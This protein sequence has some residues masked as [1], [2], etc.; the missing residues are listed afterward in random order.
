V[1]DSTGALLPFRVE[2]LPPGLTLCANGAIRDTG[3]GVIQVDLTF[4][5]ASHT[6]LDDGLTIDAQAGTIQS[7]YGGQN[8]P[9]P[10]VR[11]PSTSIDGHEVWTLTNQ[12]P[13]V[14]LIQYSGGTCWGSAATRWPTRTGRRTCRRPTRT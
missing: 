5:R 2:Y 6:G 4:K 12:Q 8:D 9:L 3:R 14:Y 13:E 10:P 1:S 7:N 11:Q